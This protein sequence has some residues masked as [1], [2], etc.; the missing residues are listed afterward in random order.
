MCLRSKAMR[1]PSAFRFI[2]KCAQKIPWT[3]RAVLHA[4]THSSGSFRKA[5]KVAGNAVPVG[6]KE[7]NT[8]ISRLRHCIRDDFHVKR[9]MAL[10]KKGLWGAGAIQTFTQPTR[11]A[12]SNKGRE[13]ELSASYISVLGWL[14]PVLLCAHKQGRLKTRLYVEPPFHWRLQRDVKN[15]FLRR[16]R[17]KTKELFRCCQGKK[18]LWKFSGGWEVVR[19]EHTRSEEKRARCE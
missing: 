5:V 19:H 3:E 13:W 12:S 4:L 2:T 15:K 18:C 7:M 17:Q 9:Q 6:G 11:R 1:T 8:E 10:L 14:S 16:N